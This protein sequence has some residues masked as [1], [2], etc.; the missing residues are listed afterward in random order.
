LKIPWAQLVH[1]LYPGESSC[2]ECWKDPNHQE[3]D[4]QVDWDDTLLKC[5]GEWIDREVELSRRPIVIDVRIAKE[6]CCEVRMAALV[7]SL[8]QY[9]NISRLHKHTLT[10]T[11]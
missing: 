4:G 7:I 8:Q 11:Q 5:D 1:L 9:L 3:M 10:S 2:E 6:S